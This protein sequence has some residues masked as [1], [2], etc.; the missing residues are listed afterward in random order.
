MM[1]AGRLASARAVDPSTTP[2]SPR[3]HGGKA[4]PAQCGQREAPTVLVNRWHRTG[5]WWRDGT[6]APKH[7][8][9]THTVTCPDPSWMYLAHLLAPPR[10]RRLDGVA[11]GQGQGKTTW[12]P[13]SCSASGRARWTALDSFRKVTVREHRGEGRSGPPKRKVAGSSQVPRSRYMPA[14][15]GPPPPRSAPRSLPFELPCPGAS[16]VHC[17]VHAALALARHGPLTWVVGAVCS[18]L[19]WTGAR[20]GRGADGWMTPPP[21]IQPSIHS[22]IHC[23][24]LPSLSFETPP[25]TPTPD[26][27]AWSSPPP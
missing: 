22:F 2:S 19:G 20:Q 1:L 9:H 13:S 23:H 26:R 21:P 16:A 12:S 14:A 10:R 4:A 3:A 17:P 15:D 5:G 25:V 11:V 27:G 6:A 18:V 24:H 7:L 8:A